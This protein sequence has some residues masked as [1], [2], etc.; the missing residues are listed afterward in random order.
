[1]SVPLCQ[2]SQERRQQHH[3]LQH[4]VSTTAFITAAGGRAHRFYRPANPLLLLLA[5][6]GCAVSRYGW[7]GEWVPRWVG[8]W[9]DGWFVGW[10]VACLLICVEDSLDERVVV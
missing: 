1:M 10:S 6:S 5:S 8:V 4:I 9:L 2:V 7:V 3:V